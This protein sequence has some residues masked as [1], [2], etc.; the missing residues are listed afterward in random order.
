MS[1]STLQQKISFYI[2]VG[3]SFIFILLS[4]PFLKI[5]YDMWQHLF[6]VGSL[7][8]EGRLFFENPE[9]DFGNIF[10]TPF[11]KIWNGKKYKTARRV[12]RKK[13]RTDKTTVCGLCVASDYIAR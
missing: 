2:L 1:D 12:I 5:P 8:D 7:F 4:N 3:I 6:G 10:K 9:F 11:K 13:I